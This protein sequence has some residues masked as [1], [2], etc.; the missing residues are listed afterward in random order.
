VHP[1][2]DFG[3]AAQKEIRAEAERIARFAAPGADTVE[4]HVA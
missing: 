4:V 2:A 3:R 1:L